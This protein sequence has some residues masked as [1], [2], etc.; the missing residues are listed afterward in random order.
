[1]TMDWTFDGTWPYEPRWFDTDDGRMQFV[2]EGPRDGAPVVMLHG[3]PTWG[4]LQE[5]AHEQ[6]VPA[7]IEHLRR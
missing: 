6:I 5:D 7:L 4:Y 1:M 3:N 2:D